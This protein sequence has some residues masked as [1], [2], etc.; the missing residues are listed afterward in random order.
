MSHLPI[1]YLLR[2]VSLQYN[3]CTCTN[4]LSTPNN[5]VQFVGKVL[6]LNIHVV[7]SDFLPMSV[8]FLSNHSIIHYSYIKAIVIYSLSHKDC[9]VDV[10]YQNKL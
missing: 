7:I 4:L 8:F 3:T 6:E 10:V 1:T 5:A 9:I 2:L